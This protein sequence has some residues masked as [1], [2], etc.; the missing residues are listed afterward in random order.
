MR[1]IKKNAFWFAAA[2]ILLLYFF[3]RFYNILGLPI[4]TDEAIY[5]RW[6]QIAANDANWR[7]I[8]LT[9]GKQP[10]YVWIAMLLM[11]V[12]EDPLLAGR[13]VSVIAGFFSTIG[14]FFLASEIFKNRK[15]G[16]LASFIYVLYPFSLLYDRMALYDSLV[17][18]FIIWVLYFEVLL[19][20]HLRLD[21]AL[22]LGMIIGAGMLTKT[23]ANFALILFPFSLLLFNF[24]DKKWKE[25]LLRWVMYAA[26]AALIANAMYLILRLSPFFHIID[27]KNLVFIYSFDEWITHPFEYL[28]NNLRAMFDWFVMYTTIPFVILILSSF[29]IG[30]KYLREKLLLLAWFVIPFIALA[31]VGKTLYPRYLLFMIMPLL[32]LGAYALYSLLS[33]TKKFWLKLLICLVFLIMFVVNGFYIITDFKK[34]S[35]PFSD[36]D[37]FYAGWPSGVGVKEI[38]EILE[39]KAK[40]EKIYVGTQGNFGLLPA[41]IEMYLGNNPNVMIKGFWP[42]H[43]NPP[44]ELIEASKRMPTYVVFYQDCPSC[45]HVGLTPPS[46]PVKTIFQVEKEQKGRFFTLY[47][48]N[49]P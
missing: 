34:A 25:K 22:I 28:W 37:Q 16:L 31:L 2:G 6:S 39:E 20:R 43:E 5:V 40:H 14:I 30:K 13:A 38:V 35:V 4:F 41:A 27:E 17:A 19:V 8:S 18:M 26:V 46:W 48:F 24:K 21:L 44:R 11:K 15:I 47:Q 12:I 49:A 7:F 3:T 29:A 32:A 9:D 45:V 42:I 33:F 1:F 10:M 36:H 23:N